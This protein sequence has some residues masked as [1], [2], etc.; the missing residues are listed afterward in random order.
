MPFLD[1]HSAPITVETLVD[2]GYKS[3][4]NVRRF[5]TAQCGPDFHFDRP[6]MQWI[7]DGT[8]KTMGDVV[9][10]WQRRKGLVEAVAGH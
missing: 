3:T 7:K 4:Q 5:M 6:L 10:E 2:P 9:R 1:W 8:D